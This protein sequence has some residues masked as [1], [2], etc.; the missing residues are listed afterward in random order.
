MKI[1]PMLLAAGVAAMS[2]SGCV[3]AVVPVAAAGVV[4]KQQ[5]DQRHGDRPSKHKKRHEDGAG[6]TAGTATATLVPADS[7]ARA[8][9][10]QGPTG[11]P[12][13]PTMQYL[14]GSA[15]AAALQR[16]TYMALAN[17][18]IAKSSDRAV[19]HPVN[20][21]VLAPGSTLD[22]PVFEPCGD[23]PLAVV[24]DVDE[25]SVLNL[26]FEGDQVMRGGAYDQARWNR[27][28]Q[29][30][31]GKVVAVPG[32]LDARK[33]AD[34]SHIAFVFNSNRTAAS[35]DATADM[36]DKVGLG[37]PKHLDTLWLD[38]DTGPKPGKDGRR[39]AIS[40]NYCVVA[41]VGDQLGDFSDL[42]N[43][44]GQS[45]A[46]RRDAVGARKIETLWG[47]GWFLLPNPVYGTALK[48]DYDAV[49]PTP[50]RWTDPADAAPLQPAQNG[51]A[52]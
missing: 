37:R 29:S 22:S 2:L 26:G 7:A 39:W 3:A 12:V 8:A 10:E 42:F 18:L 4:G 5:L 24:L 51:S 13:P 36:L 20:S 52:Q 34:I 1:A 48:G 11:T 14:Y 27:W 21:V 40:A 33:V 47:Q 35:A 31:Q 50:T 45:L 28:E 9:F 44:P 49:F 38:G 23:R 15:E 41:M 30:S 43:A 16:Q 19:G 17:Y 46:M 25:T 32:V 6:K